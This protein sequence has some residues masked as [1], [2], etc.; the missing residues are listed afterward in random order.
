M[1]PSVVLECVKLW[2]KGCE[3]P[4]ASAFHVCK[5]VDG[6]GSSAQKRFIEPAQ[7]LST[8]GGWRA[9]RWPIVPTDI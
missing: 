6:G 4:T 1:K 9:M 7:A 3:F 5:G 2:C 8:Q